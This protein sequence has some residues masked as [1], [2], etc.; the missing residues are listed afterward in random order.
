MVE[1]DA[2]E[3]LAPSSQRITCCQIQLSSM[4]K[5]IVPGS[6]S[7]EWILIIAPFQQRVKTAWL[8]WIRHSCFHVAGSELSISW[9]ETTF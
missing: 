3:V 2:T 1:N 4:R 8:L 5:P 7:C 6:E 9:T